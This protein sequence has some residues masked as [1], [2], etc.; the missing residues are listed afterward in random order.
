MQLNISGHHVELTPALKDYVNT[1]FEKLERHFDHITNCQVILQV[2]KL[3]QMAEATLHV[4]GGEI[5][6]KAENE[7]MY[8]AIDGLVDKL[9]RQIL[10]YKEKNVDRMH[11]SASR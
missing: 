10:K 8:A 3:R 5:H 1:K 2:E 7:D 11:G 4:S 6:A 9:D